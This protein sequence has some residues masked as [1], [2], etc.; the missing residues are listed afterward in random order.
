MNCQIIGLRVDN[1]RHCAPKLQQALTGYGCSI[2]MRIGLH[3][4]SDQFCS[5]NGLILLQVQGDSEATGKMVQ[6]LN[7]LAGVTA[8][9]MEI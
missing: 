3:E 6:D 7:G 5:D 2:K 9:M 1:R 8:K 4:A